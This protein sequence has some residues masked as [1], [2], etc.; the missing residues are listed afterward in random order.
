MKTP[1]GKTGCAPCPVTT[2]QAPKAFKDRNLVG[3][4]P[5]TQQ[6]EPTPAAPIAQRK[7]MAGGG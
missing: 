4:S 5:R 7:R 6:F 2:P 1:A 3:V